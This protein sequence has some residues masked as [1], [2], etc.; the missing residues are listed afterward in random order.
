MTRCESACR[1]APPGPL[2][3]RFRTIADKGRFWLGTVC[4]LLTRSRHWASTDALENQHQRIAARLRST[5]LYVLDPAGDKASM[6]EYLKRWFPFRGRISRLAILYFDSTLF[7]HL[8]FGAPCFWR[9]LP[10]YTLTGSERGR[11]TQSCN[12]SRGCLCRNY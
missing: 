4:P 8:V 10:A 7:A 2:F 6:R 3:G 9:S 5:Y 11:I 12:L 1:A